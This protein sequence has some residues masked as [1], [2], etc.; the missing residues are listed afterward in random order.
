ML[1]KDNEKKCKQYCVP[2]ADQMLVTLAS[3]IQHPPRGSFALAVET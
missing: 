2:H 1:E 3:F